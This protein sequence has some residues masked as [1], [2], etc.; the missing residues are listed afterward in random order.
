MSAAPR[1]I[2]VAALSV[3]GLALGIAAC[4]FDDESG[5]HE[6]K[7]IRPPAQP[8]EAMPSIDTGATLEILA[9]SAGDVV[10]ANTVETQVKLDH[11]KVDCRFAGTPNRDGI[12]HYH[13]ELDGTLID[14]YCGDSAKV[15]LQNVRPGEHELEVVPAA[16]DHT[17]DL[18]ELKKVA[19][20]YQ[21]T[22]APKPLEAVA[23]PG[24]PGITIVAPKPGS[25][26]SE[27]FDLVVKPT[28]FRFSCALYGKDDLAGW[29]HWHAN[30]DATD[31]GMMGMG[32]MLGM[33]CMRRFHVSLAG[34]E[35]GKHTF[36]AILEDNQHA[37]TPEV[38]DSV[39]L[40][41]K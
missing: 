23:N 33:S 17:D 18:D 4:G 41:V 12:G 35:P 32:T 16:N 39:E 31:K 11:F 29:G 14:M 38:Q 2:A 7:P 24:R 20:D 9:P 15:S 34:I 28:N 1:R 36:F 5:T 37:P 21:P 22:E 3:A 30:V 27:S 25:T 40:D 13:V 26:V 10:D 6:E 19:F 8:E